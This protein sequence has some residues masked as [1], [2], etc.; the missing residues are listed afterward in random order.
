MI[1]HHLA[2]I[3][4]IVLV[5]LILA[6]YAAFVGQYPAPKILYVFVIIALILPSVWTLRIYKN[7]NAVI[8]RTG[9]KILDASKGVPYPS[10]AIALSPAALLALV[11]LVFWIAASAPVSI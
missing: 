10:L 2:V 8:K 9:R 7:E 1:Y 3:P 6:P 4:G 5:L 11:L